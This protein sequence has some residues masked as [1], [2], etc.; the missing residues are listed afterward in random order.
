[1]GDS[2]A[3]PLVASPAD[4]RHP[5]LSP[6]GKWLAYASTVSGAA[7][8]YVRPYPQ[9]GPSVLVSMRGGTEPLWSHSGT[10]LFYRS[11]SRIMSARRSSSGA[12]ATPQLLFTGAF[13]FSQ[14]MNWSVGPDDAF[15]MVKADPTTGRQL[16]VVFDWFDELTGTGSSTANH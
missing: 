11:G 12:F 2:I 13:D 14:E 8:V 3:T 16:R 4:E 1:M 7:E 6:D 5:R 15:I 10:E 9:T